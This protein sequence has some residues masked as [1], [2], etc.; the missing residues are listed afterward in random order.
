MTDKSLISTE[1]EL[2]YSRLDQR[3]AELNDGDCAA[4]GRCCDFAKFDHRLFVTAVEMVYFIQKVPVERM[5]GGVCP[6]QKGWLCSVHEHRFAGCRIFR[7]RS[8]EQAQ[9]RLAEQTLDE[10]KELS[11]RFD[12]A[13]RYMDLA[14][15]LNSDVPAGQD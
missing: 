1:V 5:V 2:I 4:C 13:W 11:R 12:V 7:C 6:Y 14:A 3:I 9:G 15:A 10:F 8:D